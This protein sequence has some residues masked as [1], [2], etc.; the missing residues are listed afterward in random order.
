[1]ITIK[2]ATLLECLAGTH[3]CFDDDQQT[4]DWSTDQVGHL[5][6]PLISE[7]HSFFAPPYSRQG[8]RRYDKYY[9]GSFSSRLLGSGGQSLLDG[10]QLLITMVLL[11]TCVHNLQ[12]DGFCRVDL[13][14]L[15]SKYLYGE[16]TLSLDIEI[17][18]DVLM[19]LID[20]HNIE[21]G[22][23]T[24]V[25]QNLVDRYRDIEEWLRTNFEDSALPYFGHW[26]IHCTYMRVHTADCDHGASILQ[27][28]HAYDRRMFG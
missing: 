10:H 6:H 28:A 16:R 1:M 4:Y 13:N 24:E 7:F 23:V 11:L 22:H 18:E 8:G 15:I 9:L 3:Y 2:D 20:G 14:S 26:L 17:Y 27:K 21:P 19:D 5:M 12:G 25:S